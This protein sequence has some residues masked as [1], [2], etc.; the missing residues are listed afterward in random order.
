[1]VIHVP[2]IIFDFCNW[3]PVW[4]FCGCGALLLIAIIEAY[5]EYILK[6]EGT[7]E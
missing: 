5:N 6:R 4:V 7:N 1:M 2:I 3:V